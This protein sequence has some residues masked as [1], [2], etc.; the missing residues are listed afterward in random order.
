MR[1]ADGQARVTVRGA[2]EGRAEGARLV[3]ASTPRLG[4]TRLIAIDGP[5][6]SG[7]TSLAAPLAEA[8]A[9]GLGGEVVRTPATGSAPPGQAGLPGESVPAGAAAPPG[10]SVRSGDR[11]TVAVVSTDLLATWDDPFDW[12]PTLVRR[13]LEPLAAGRAAALPVVDWVAG[14]PRP[15]GRII[16]PPVDVL[17]VEGV[18]S[19]RLAVADRLSAL[20]WVEVPGRQAR[21]ERAVARD[22][23]G[24]RPL[25]ARWQRAEAAH[26]A[27]QHTRRRADL[28]IDLS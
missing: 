22:G 12:W 8:V 23:E 13:L 19:G 18:S 21:L 28:V 24:S 16:V 11:P 1:A 3:L 7:K 5:S 14:Q 9:A 17:I 10:E 4:A 20:I 15:G 27:V 2:Q 26:F 25:L 6:G